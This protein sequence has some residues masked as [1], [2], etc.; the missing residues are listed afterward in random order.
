MTELSP[1]C[2]LLAQHLKLGYVCIHIL[3]KFLALILTELMSNADADQL[4][5]A[6]RQRL[7]SLFALT[8]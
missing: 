8:E 2:S 5:F 7:A 3:K 1:L 4:R 6:I